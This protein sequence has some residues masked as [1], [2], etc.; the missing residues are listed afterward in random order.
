MNFKYKVRH[1]RN[2]FIIIIIILYLSLIFGVPTLLGSTHYIFIYIDLVL[3]LFPAQLMLMGGV[4]GWEK[5]ACICD[6]QPE[7]CAM[8]V[9]HL[10]ICISAER[11]SFP[12]VL[13][14]F[15]QIISVFLLL[16]IRTLRHRGYLC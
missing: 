4:C 16:A 1:L 11:S 9:C 8:W 15:T 7:P 2:D 10:I 5:A 14:H 12:M 3:F 6:I 13:G